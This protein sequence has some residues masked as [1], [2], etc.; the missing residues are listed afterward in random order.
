LSPKPA[1]KQVGL[2]SPEGGVVLVA[3]AERD[4]G[5]GLTGVV[6]HQVE[7]GEARIRLLI[8]A[9]HLDQVRGRGKALHDRAQRQVV[10]L[11]D[12]DRN[13]HADSARGWVIR[14]QQ[15]EGAGLEQIAQ[16]EDSKVGRPGERIGGLHCE[17]RD[18]VRVHQVDGDRVGERDGQGWKSGGG[19]TRHIGGRNLNELGV[20]VD[21]RDRIVCIG[22]GQREVGKSFEN[23]WW[24]NSR[25]AAGRVEDDLEVEVCRVQEIEVGGD[26]KILRPAP[27]IVGLHGHAGVAI[28]VIERDVA[29][30]EKLHDAGSYG[31]FGNRK[32]YRLGERRIGNQRAKA[33]REGSGSRWVATILCRVGR[34]KELRLRHRAKSDAGE[35][36]SLVGEHHVAQDHAD[37]GQGLLVSI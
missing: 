1:L 30:G 7:C 26:T 23:H 10:E 14:N 11:L 37:I 25:G 17:V 24:S 32:G 20:G 18:I 6:I 21:L 8:E 28:G 16:G 22:L 13:L 29:G 27:W 19:S 2:G 4:G 33:D 35:G 15:V 12:D 36:E 9:F 3:S 5:H 34:Q 31:R